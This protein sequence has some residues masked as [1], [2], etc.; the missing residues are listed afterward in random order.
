MP[1]EKGAS[2]GTK[3]N[4]ESWRVKQRRLRNRLSQK[5]VRERKAARIQQLEQQLATVT[6]EDDSARVNELLDTNTRL[7]HA[8]LD[9]RKR[10]TSLSATATQLGQRIK[11]ELDQR[12][13][14][15]DDVTNNQIDLLDNQANHFWIANPQ[16]SS[17]SSPASSNDSIPINVDPERFDDANLEL[18]NPCAS[19]DSEVPFATSMSGHSDKITLSMDAMGYGSRNNKATSA[20][21]LGPFLGPKLRV[22][23]GSTF[24]D[25]LD[26]IHS[27]LR[28][29]GAL[30]GGSRSAIRPFSFSSLEDLESLMLCSMPPQLV[31]SMFAAFIQHGWPSMKYWFDATQSGLLG[32]RVL[33]WQTSSSHEAA[34]Q[35]PPGNAPTLIQLSQPKYPCILDWVPHP[36][37]RDLLILNYRS[38]DVDQVICDMTNA[39]VVEVEESKPVIDQ[40]HPALHLPSV[41][42]GYSY[43]LMEL[44]EQS[45]D[46]GPME[47]Q[48]PQEL[49]VMR[50]LQSTKSSECSSVRHPIHRFK[51]DPRFFDKYPALYDADAESKYRPKNPP[52]VSRS[53]LPL[54]FTRD[55][56]K[57]YMNAI[58][59]AKRTMVA[60]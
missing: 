38:Y 36:G 28:L 57:E 43:N 54:P 45:L 8:L 16:T 53:Q 27:L 33:W 39:F 34:T 20:L 44:V 5:A 31:K 37:L 25:H 50:L 46:F 23:S 4:A 59:H 41:S 40:A 24:S 11:D 56:V 1:P 55:S 58:L 10:L 13:H 29:G 14:D 21:F 18:I 60:A 30:E 47:N 12:E 15:S 49:T 19:V 22:Y 51:L 42:T 48:N 32:A 52:F 6:K 9:T 35:I 17:Q 7:R 3:E 26:H 2:K